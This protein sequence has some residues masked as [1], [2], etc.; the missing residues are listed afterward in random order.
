M[1]REGEVEE[2]P[3]RQQ[4]AHAGEPLARRPRHERVVAHAAEDDRHGGQQVGREIEQE[5][6]RRIVGG[7]DDGDLGRRVLRRHQR[8]HLRVELLAAPP[9]VQELHRQVV[10]RRL[11]LEPGADAAGQLIGPAV[12]QVVGVDQQDAARRRLRPRG[13]RGSQ[14]NPH[15]PE[16]RGQES[17]TRHSA[18]QQ[19]GSSA[20]RQPTTVAWTPAPGSGSE[21]AS[22]STAWR[23]G[24]ERRRHVSIETAAPRGAMCRRCRRR[25]A[26]R[27]ATRAT[28]RDG[29]DGPRS[30]PAT[31]VRRHA[32]G[33]SSVA[34]RQESRRCG[35]ACRAA[36]EGLVRR[37]DPSVAN[38]REDGDQRC[39]QR[40]EGRGTGLRRDAGPCGERVRSRGTE[41]VQIAAGELAPC[42]AGVDA[43]RRRHPHGRLLRAVPPDSHP[44]RERRVA[45]PVRRLLEGAGR[46]ALRHARVAQQLFQPV[47][48]R[49]RNPPLRARVRQPAEGE[50]RRVPRIDDVGAVAR[51]PHLH[52]GRRL[53]G[54]GLRALHA[55]VDGQQRGPR[56]AVLQA[57]RRRQPERRLARR[58]PFVER[59][60]RPAE[61]EDLRAR[62]AEP[63]PPRR[64][65]T[66]VVVADRDDL[67]ALGA[68]RR[69]KRH[70]VPDLCREQRLGQRRAPRHARVA[71]VELVH[72]HNSDLALVAG[73]VLERHR[74]AEV[75]A[76]V[77]PARVVDH[78]GLV[79]RLRQVADAPIDLAQLLLAVD[80]V[81]VLGAIAVA[82]GPRDRRDDG[83]PLLLPQA[84]ELLLQSA[85][86]ARR[87]VVLDLV[88]HEIR[89]S[90]RQRQQQSTCYVRGSRLA[91]RSGPAP[92]ARAPAGRHRADAY[93]DPA[94]SHGDGP[95]TGAA[96]GG[97]A[98]SRA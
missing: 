20:R 19:G 76:P 58:Q 22:A 90:A 13:R 44:T 29:R 83:R 39:S 61:S 78:G 23:S 49:L 43:R 47:G 60:D 1:Q 15:N 40:L 28:S 12:A 8:A 54:R 75:D 27:Q 96:L 68:A 51:P 73:F 50:R 48:Q 66:Q 70:R 34:A 37:E 3:D 24:R 63:C 38:R 87:D 93:P 21:A 88:A 95:T 52:E 72:A 92:A 2:R 82:R 6:Q 4:L 7:D 94:L 42:L 80:V 74:G 79:E 10:G 31:P 56:H 67:E 45:Q 53:P 98:Q 65:A 35:A 55:C 46:R 86:A 84:R 69:A 25:R 57:R 5:L 71:A 30:R 41:D 62:H 17:A 11:P 36:Q 64:M 85:V 32:G 33:G 81:A 59:L 89:G 9:G 14:S 18:K 91:L 26:A 77:R 97:H 16:D